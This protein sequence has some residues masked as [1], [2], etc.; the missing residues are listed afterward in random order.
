MLCN[1]LFV[2]FCWWFVLY[3]ASEPEVASW[4]SSVLVPWQQIITQALVWSMDPAMAAF[5]ANQDLWHNLGSDRGELKKEEEGTLLR[6][7]EQEAVLC[8]A[9]I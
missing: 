6:R 4:Y 8:Q 7:T 1:P 5:L 2:S 9:S 3:P